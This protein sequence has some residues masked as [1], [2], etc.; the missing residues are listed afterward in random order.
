[1]LACIVCFGKSDDPMVWGFN[2]GILFML[3]ILAGVLV[4]FLIF[5]IYLVRRSKKMNA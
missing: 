3:G 2:A 1:M 4:S 5:I